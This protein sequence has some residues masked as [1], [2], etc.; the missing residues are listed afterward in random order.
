MPAHPAT[1]GRRDRHAKMH[2]KHEDELCREATH[3]WVKRGNRIEGIG[4]VVD[5]A[6][7]LERHAC[8]RS[9]QEPAGVAEIGMTRK[10]LGSLPGGPYPN[11][12]HE[13]E[14]YHQHVP[15]LVHCRTEYTACLAW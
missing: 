14:D 9:E 1:C 4:R 7:H 10:G 5:E 8:A 3:D 13:H 6:D 2:K 15:S 11:T 12:D